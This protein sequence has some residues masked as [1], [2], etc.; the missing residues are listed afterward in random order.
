[1]IPASA[2][3]AALATD[4]QLAVERGELSLAFQP[5]V[6]IAS[7]RLTGVEALSRWDHPMLGAIDPERFVPVAERYGLIDQ[8]TDWLIGAGLKQWSAWKDQG[9][10]A[11]LAFNISALSLRD[12]YFPDYLHRLCLIEGV[13]PSCLTIEVTEG[14][15]QH[16]VRLLDTL[17]RFRLK[18]MSLSLDDFGTGYSSL[19]QLRQLPYCELKIDRCFVRDAATSRESRLI[20]KAVIDLAHGLGLS[21][22]AEGVEDEATLALLAGLGCDNAQG[23]FIAR[24]MQGSELAPWLIEADAARTI[25][26]ISAAAAGRG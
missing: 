25:I 7:G 10:K 4:L 2:D 12:I 11:N 26:P 24:P 3:E 8:L 21:A 15:T 18:G 16:L 20:V 17:T 22:T 6:E 13:P 1:M 19:L 14:A 9:L 23:F 5:K